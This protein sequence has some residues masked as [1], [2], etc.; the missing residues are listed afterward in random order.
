VDRGGCQRLVP[1]A[2]KLLFQW[3]FGPFLFC[4]PFGLDELAPIANL[5]PIMALKPAARPIPSIR[6]VAFDP[7]LPLTGIWLLGGRRA[8]QTSRNRRGLET[9]WRGAANRNADRAA[10]QTVVEAPPLESVRRSTGEK[11]DRSAAEQ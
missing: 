4:V 11:E 1:G 8:R 9:G 2:A 10:I 7:P 6:P 3:C 5:I